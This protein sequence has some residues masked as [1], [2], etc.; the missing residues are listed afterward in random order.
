MFAFSINK[1]WSLR[2][3]TS[4]LIEMANSC[5]RRSIY[6]DPRDDHV[7]ENKHVCRFI[8]GEL[9]DRVNVA[10]DRKFLTTFFWILLPE[11]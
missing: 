6:I 7:R 9:A 8:S 4:G 3:K 1:S 2:W 11:L 10:K 5:S